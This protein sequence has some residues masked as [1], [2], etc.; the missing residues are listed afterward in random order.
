MGIVIRDV[1]RKPGGMSCAYLALPMASPWPART[2]NAFPTKFLSA[3]ILHVRLSLVDIAHEFR[4]SISSSMIGVRWGNKFRFP[5]CSGSP[6]SASTRESILPLQNRE[7]WLLMIL[8]T[9][10][11]RNVG[12]NSGKKSVERIAL[13]VRAQRGRDI[14]Q[15]GFALPP[16]FLAKALF[17]R[18]PL[19][20]RFS[21]LP[22]V[23]SWW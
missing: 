14:A 15:N 23:T 8:K 1:A 12:W 2:T 19:F 9:W 18:S 22:P 10:L 7:L 6:C 21:C 3:F 16:S 4:L 17:V 13:V 20:R 11:R 5:H